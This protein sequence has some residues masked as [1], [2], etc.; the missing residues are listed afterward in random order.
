MTT[1]DTPT[2]AATQAVLAVVRD[3]LREAE[4]PLRATLDQ[5]TARLA[6]LDTE[7]VELN[8]ARRRI[9]GTL[10]TLDPDRPLS[11]V[12]TGTTKPSRE[13]NRHTVRGPKG[14]E[15]AAIVEKWVYAHAPELVDGFTGAEIDR[16]I[17]ENGG[18]PHPISADLVRSVLDDMHER[19]ILRLDRLVKGGGRLYKMIEGEQQ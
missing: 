12:K 18:S 8:E 2:A 6:T 14:R 19:G 9:E 11:G 3:Q 5:I 13:R 15:S 17:R 16:R 7:R 1:T 10:R 4:A